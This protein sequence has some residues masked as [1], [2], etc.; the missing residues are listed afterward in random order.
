MEAILRLIQKGGESRD[1]GQ[2]T[3]VPVGTTAKSLADF[4]VEHIAELISWRE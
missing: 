4:S 1:S 2:I 3:S